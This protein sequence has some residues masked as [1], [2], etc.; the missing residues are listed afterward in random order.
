MVKDYYVISTA[1]ENTL[2]NVDFFLS[3][4]YDDYF[5]ID[6]IIKNIVLEKSI[7]N[8]YGD[9]GD[10]EDLVLE[11]LIDAKNNEDLVFYDD[12][13]DNNEA[14][15]ILEKEIKKLSYKKS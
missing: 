4:N 6:D 5:L 15:K 3:K 2:T 12:C 1:L 7:P 8:V 10:L 13:N 11:A 14:I 9:E